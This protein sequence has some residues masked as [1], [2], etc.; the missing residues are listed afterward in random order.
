[1]SSVTGQIV[2]LRSKTLE[3]KV[4]V[5]AREQKKKTC[6]LLYVYRFERNREI[7]GIYKGILR[8]P[9]AE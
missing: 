4:V 3:L 9:K 6:L 1:M 5:S 2:C 8:Y 7:I